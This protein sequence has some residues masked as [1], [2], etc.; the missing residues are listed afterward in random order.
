[1]ISM[2]DNC[3]V[4]AECD[5]YK[6]LAGETRVCMPFSNIKDLVSVT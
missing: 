5:E 1:M 2:E 4:L 3:Y 6:N